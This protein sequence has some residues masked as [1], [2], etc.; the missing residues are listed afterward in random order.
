MAHTE[1]AAWHASGLSDLGRSPLSSSGTATE[2]INAVNAPQ[3]GDPLQEVSRRRLQRV[4]SMYTIFGI[5]LHVRDS[6]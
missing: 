3:G 6:E 5:G 2:I 4:R 1:Q